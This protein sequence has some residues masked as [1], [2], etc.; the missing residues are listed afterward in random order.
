MSFF[1]GNDRF[2][3]PYRDIRAG[4]YIIDGTR[5][6]PCL[7]LAEE[8]VLDC[9]DGDSSMTIAD[10]RAELDAYEKALAEWKV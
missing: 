9:D 3:K 1:D 7:W 5:R 8:Y 2:P 10:I 4:D 6:K